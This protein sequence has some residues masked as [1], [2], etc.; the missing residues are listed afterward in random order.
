MFLLDSDMVS[1]FHAGHPQVVEQV[2]RVDPAEIIGTTVITQGEIL[3][4]RFAFLLTAKDGEQLQEAQRWLDRSFA[5]LADLTIIPID[6]AVAKRFD[7][8][9]NQKRVASIGRADLLI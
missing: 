2:D 3:R 4:A 8:L 1:L 9:R 5:L 7:A 6:V